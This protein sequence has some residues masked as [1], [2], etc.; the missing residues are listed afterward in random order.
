[1][2]KGGSHQK[3]CY[4]YMNEGRSYQMFCYMD[5]LSALWLLK[6]VMRREK[7]LLSREHYLFRNTDLLCH[8]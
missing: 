2:N 6:R 1:M 7:A 4:I 5:N 3:F 8:R